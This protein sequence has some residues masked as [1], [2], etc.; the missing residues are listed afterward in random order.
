MFALWRIMRAGASILVFIMLLHRAISGD[1]QQLSDFMMVVL[2]LL[3]H[4]TFS[5]QRF[6]TDFLAERA[7]GNMER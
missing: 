5:L 4:N 6:S 1:F 3:R 7:C 2:C